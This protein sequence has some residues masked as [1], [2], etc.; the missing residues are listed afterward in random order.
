M[1]DYVEVRLD[2]KPFPGEDATDLIAALLGDIGYESFVPDATGVTAY[3]PVAAYSA[4]ALDEALADFPYDCTID[5]RVT[6]IEGRDW[7]AEWERHYFQPIVIAGRCVVHSSFHTDIPE[8][9]YDIVIDPKMA[10][11]TGHHAT[12][13]QVAAALLDMD[14]T[15]LRLIDMG[16]GT[17]ILAILAAMHGAADVLGVEIDEFAYVNAVENVRLNGHPEIR[18]VHGDASALAGERAA[19]VLVAN[20]NRNIILADIAAYARA[21]RPGGRMVLS[22]FYTDDIPMI[23]EA[24]APLGLH[25]AARTER[26]RW[27]CLILKKDA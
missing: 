19:D 3:V 14:L 2:P 24:A 18:L 10:F 8:A 4:D 11:G 17:G 16:T 1:N 21:L 13:S 25:E 15:G 20:I 7:N 27:A 26:D 5:R 22:G 12:T 6:T 9:P 23:A